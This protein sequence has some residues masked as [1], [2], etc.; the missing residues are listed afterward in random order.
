MSNLKC[1]PLPVCCSDWS[2]KC[3]ITIH[4]Q[5]LIEGF[6]L[7]V[8]LSLNLSLI[9][10]LDL[11]AMHEAA[12]LLVGTHDFSSF[13]AVNS[14]IHFKNPV[15]TMDAVTIQPGCSFAQAHFHR[16]AT[17]CIQVTVLTSTNLKRYMHFLTFKLHESANNNNP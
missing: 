8:H 5:I 2:L 3:I 9:R 12:A 10:A 11:E 6:F 1:P 16:W 13:R 7:N 17:V 4:L 14:D 15:K